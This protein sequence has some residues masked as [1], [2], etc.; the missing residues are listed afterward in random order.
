MAQG[1]CTTDGC[2]K[3]AIKKQLCN[4]CYQRTRYVW[5]KDRPFVLNGAVCKTCG[6]L[7]R[8]N[9]HGQWRYCSVA[10]RP[11]LPERPCE[12]CG[13]IFRPTHRGH[14][15]VGQRFCS[16]PCARRTQYSWYTTK[17]GYVQMNARGGGVILQHRAVMQNMLDRPLEGDENVH[18]KNGD[19]ADNR[20]EN[21]ELWVTCQPYGQRVE[22][23]LAWAHEIIRRYGGESR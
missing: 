2:D 5:M 1:T 22:D 10:C 16:V 6:E 12:H 3:V 23:V 21:L 14:A 18:H 17:S 8:V 9:G 13:V 7:F 4:R 19:R 11:V 15:G 20:P